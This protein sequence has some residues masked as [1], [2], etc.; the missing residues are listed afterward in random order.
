MVV[1][2]DSNFRVNAASNLLKAMAS[3]HRL[4]LLCALQSGEQ[5]VSELSANVPLRQ[6]ALSQHL[7][8]LRHQGLVQSRRQGQSVYYRLSP[9]PAQ[10]LIRDLYEAYCES[11]NE[12]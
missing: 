1:L 12:K 11:S 7:A 9:G 6:P 4:S 3:P 2:L 8:V 5:S 10:N